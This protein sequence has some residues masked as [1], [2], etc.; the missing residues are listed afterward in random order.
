MTSTCNPPRNP[1]DSVFIIQPHS[2]PDSTRT[3][4]FF[5]SSLRVL[6]PYRR[7]LPSR[8]SLSFPAKKTTISP[9][10]E[11]PGRISL[12]FTF[13]SRFL[14]FS[15]S[16]FISFSLCGVCLLSP[17]LP[18]SAFTLPAAANYSIYL[19]INRLPLSHSSRSYCLVALPNS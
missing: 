7:H 5:P 15:F 19:S 1:R 8:A 11:H 2:D 13:C 12:L 3:L 18:L 10:Q 16:P 6:G 4:F 14:P 9:N 17:L